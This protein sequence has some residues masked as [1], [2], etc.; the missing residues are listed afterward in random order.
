MTLTLSYTCPS[1]PGFDAPCINKSAE[2]KN[3]SLKP[4]CLQVGGLC[5][6][7]KCNMGI[8]RSTEGLFLIYP[9][10]Q[11]QYTITSQ[12][13]TTQSTIKVLENTH[14][15]NRSLKIENVT[16][17]DDFFTT[18]QHKTEDHPKIQISDTIFLR[19]LIILVWN[20]SVFLRSKMAA[21]QSYNEKHGIRNV[22]I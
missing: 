9:A 11:T 4:K 10:S 6:D 1:R 17:M 16:K 12:R 22:V 18:C 14:T 3:L 13:K 20:R 8:S 21:F 2:T 19:S 5:P 7:E 15:I